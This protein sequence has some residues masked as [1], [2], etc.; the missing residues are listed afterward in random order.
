MRKQSMRKLF[1]C[2]LLLAA[3]L[4]PGIA[5]AA[6]AI[7]VSGNSVTILGSAQTISLTCTLIDPNQTGLLKSGSNIITVFVTNSATPG[8]T[9]TCGPIYANDTIADGLGNL[10]TTYYKVAVF[11]VTGGIVASSPAKQGFY[12]FTGSGTIDLATATPLAPSF[13]TGPSGSVSMP[14]SL[15]VAGAA[16]LNGGATVNG[17][18]IPTIPI[19]LAT[20]VTGTLPGANYAAVNLAAGNV[21]GGA[22]GT[23]PAANLPATTGQCTGVQFSRGQAAGGSENCAT[24]PTFV[25]S[26]A[27]HAVGYVPDPGASAGTTHFL[28]EDATW[29]TL[30]ASG[31]SEATWS[32]S[33][34]LAIG[35]F[36][37]NAQIGG[38]IFPSGHTL[39][40]YTIWMTG[41][42]SGCTTSP[43]LAFRDVTGSTNLASL[44]V[45]N[46]TTFFDSGA[47]SVSMT[48]GHQFAVQVTTAGSG[49]SLGA[50]G[51]TATVFYQ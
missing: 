49:C 40:R 44:T 9:A 20:Q 23:L 11:T 29:A 43:V 18:A 27:S 51:F 4:S 39:I 2:L 33:N 12:A 47:L 3:I 22:T 31:V 46:G 19:N 26:G 25:A 41:T 36:V 48:G 32:T 42:V 35:S 6:P 16:A 28:R 37:L 10:S 24:P 1:G 45:T 13:F 34:G 14:G 8:T 38:T 17:A 50:S 5:A 30:P 15:T 7:T 21:N